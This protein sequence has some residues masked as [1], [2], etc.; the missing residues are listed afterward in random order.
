[1]TPDPV[2]AEALA[3]ATLAGLG[4]SLLVPARRGQ[5]VATSAPTSSGPVPPLLVVAVVGFGTLGLWSSLDVHAVVLVAE[6]AV[7]L[8]AVL[9]LVRRGRQA[10][11]ADARS[12][13]VQSAC[14]AMASDLAA[15]QPPLRCLDRAAREWAELAPAAVAARMGADVP[16]ALRE[17]AELPGAGQ[18]RTV[19]ATWQVAHSTGAGL[20]AALARA[21]ESIRS[22]RRTTRLV[23]AELSAAHATARMLAVLPV[24]VLLLGA[25]IGGDPVGFLTGTTAGLVC[26]GLGLGLS[27]GGL[28]WIESIADRVLR[29]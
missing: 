7:V 17:L 15:G 18:L 16:A 20:A 5:G 24:A 26:L 6:L 25:G 19:A 4:V 23:A 10:R 8:A 22:E 1:M 13:E 14:D 12:Q 29:R 3:A 9:R 11:A 2:A 21:A 28:T 27:L